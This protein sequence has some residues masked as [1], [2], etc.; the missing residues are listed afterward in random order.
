MDSHQNERKKRDTS[1][2]HRW[3]LDKA[4]E[5]FIKKGFA[6]ASMD[7]IA[8]TAG[9]SKRTIY[10]H[11]QSKENLFQ[12]IVA[13]F[14]ADSDR[15][16]PGQYSEDLSLE[17]QL[18]SFAR[19]EMY[20]IDDPLRRGLSRL[21]T[22]VFLMDTDLGIA[23]RGRYSPH[24]A[25]ITWLESAREEGRLA[26][27]SPPLAARIFYG[28]VEGCITWG[29]MIS[30]GKNMDGIDPLLDEIIAVFLARYG[31]N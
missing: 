9:V 29:A 30:D 19:A 11:F 25:L 6:A 16:K 3:I 13:L 20:L 27:P 12:E 17:E 4:V 1:K 26:I 28:L 10:N 21:L 31:R 24:Q 18:L 8:D 5:V 7:E 22:S 15:I 14:L 23:T 2:K